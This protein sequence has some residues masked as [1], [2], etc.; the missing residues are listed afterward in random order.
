MSTHCHDDL[1]LST[2]NSM[3]GV[4]AGKFFWG[5]GGGGGASSVFKYWYGPFHLFKP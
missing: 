3:A 1:G 5:D 4:M 2:A